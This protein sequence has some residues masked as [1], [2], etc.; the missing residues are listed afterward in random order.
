MGSYGGIE[1]YILTLAAYLQ[2]LS[3]FRV[4]VIFKKVK[5]FQLG[6]D[7]EQILRET[8]AEVKFVNRASIALWREITWADV[9]HAQN[10]SPD[11]A[12]FSFLLRKPLILTIYYNFLMKFSVHKALWKFVAQRATMCLYISD[13]V[14]RTWEDAI[15]K[16]KSAVIYPISRFPQGGIVPCEKRKGFVFVARWIENK[17]LDILVEAYHAATFEKRQWPLRL[18]GTGPLRAKIEEN[19]RDNQIEGIEI[20]GFVSDDKKAEIIRSAKWVVAPAN[21]REDLGLVP[22]EARSVGVPCIVTRDGG[23]PESGGKEALLCEPGSV[24]DLRRALEKAAT[25]D[26][27]EYA[28]RSYST[29]SELDEQLKPLT[30]Y[31]ELYQS[32]LK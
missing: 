21:T 3:D 26:H 10:A 19:I 15:G 32:L 11:T 27:A 25:M 28:R 22:F 6:S 31:T 1:A 16:R 13:F 14:R 4:R 30:C 8:P 29:R 7:L 9:V 17:G 24:E 18:I 2:Q 5:Q 20:L 12:L 23:L